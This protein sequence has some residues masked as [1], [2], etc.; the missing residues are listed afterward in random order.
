MSK[1][2]LRDHV[3][4][5]NPQHVAHDKAGDIVDV[6]LV[7]GGYL[8]DIEGR[9]FTLFTHELVLADKERGE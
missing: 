1:F 5:T 2:K 6:A 8:V 3:R 9:K 4:V 7:A